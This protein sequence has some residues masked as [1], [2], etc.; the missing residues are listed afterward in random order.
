[1]MLSGSVI[2]AGSFLAVY[3][4]DAL[5]ASGRLDSRPAGSPR[6]SPQTRGRGARHDAA[7]VQK[8]L[9]LPARGPDPRRLFEA[10]QGR[11]AEVI[12]GELL[13]PDEFVHHV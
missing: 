12:E 7:I 2:V 10:L 9:R 1:M 3:V 5:A 6:A 4:F 8:P 11:L 13:A